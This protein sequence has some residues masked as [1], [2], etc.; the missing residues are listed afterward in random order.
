MGS[1]I[2]TSNHVIQLKV[3]RK[4]KH[5]LSHTWEAWFLYTQEMKKIQR[6]QSRLS[7]MKCTRILQDWRL[8][9]VSTTFAHRIC[10]T[11]NQSIKH[12]ILSYWRHCVVTLK[13]LER[14]CFKQS[15]RFKHLLVASGRLNRTFWR[16]QM[17]LQLIEW[18]VQT[19]YLIRLSQALAWSYTKIQRRSVL[20]WRSAWYESK[21]RRVK[22]FKA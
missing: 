19:R 7:E 20:A 10:L 2:K 12:R 15:K 5:L 8:H 11:I 3:I 14:I 9:T 1:W 18:R 22:S 13:N 6:I 17:R 21:M 4:W 16:I